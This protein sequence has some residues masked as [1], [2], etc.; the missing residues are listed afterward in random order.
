MSK[1]NLILRMSGDC[2]GRAVRS[3]FVFCVLKHLVICLSGSEECYN[4]AWLRSSRNVLGTMKLHLT[5]QE[6]GDKE[7]IKTFS[8]LVELIL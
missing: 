2:T 7:I 3:H 5:S 1:S 4:A 8:F 6:G